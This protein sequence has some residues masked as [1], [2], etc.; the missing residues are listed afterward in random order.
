MTRSKKTRKVK[1]DSRAP[2]PKLDKASLALLDKKPKKKTGKTSGN[3]Q[4]EA[5]KA[6]TTNTTNKNA[7]DPRLGS[8]KPIDLGRPLPVK[9]KPA[10]KKKA[11]GIAKV[12]LLDQTSSPS[13]RL[14]EIE[15]D[16]ALLAII[17]KQEMGEALSEQEVNYFN[18]LMEEHSKITEELGIEDDVDDSA[19]AELSEDELW[20]KLDTTDFSDF[21]HSEDE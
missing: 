16:T 3:K 21:D 14:A 13:D 15:Q 18:D 2:K 20:N 12:K 7:K 17:S 11:T 10:A 5:T 4:Q 9:Q 6:S 8:K 19:N 1:L